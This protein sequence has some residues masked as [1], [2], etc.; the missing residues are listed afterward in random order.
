MRAPGV[1]GP[2]P[3]EPGSRNPPAAPCQQVQVGAVTRRPPAGGQ[4]DQGHVLEGTELLPNLGHQPGKCPAQAPGQGDGRLSLLH[5]L[6]RRCLAP[7]RQRLPQRERD[8]MRRWLSLRPRQLQHRPPLGGET[9]GTGGTA[10]AAARTH[11]DTGRLPVAEQLRRHTQHGFSLPALACAEEG[12]GHP[13]L[14]GTRQPGEAGARR[15]AG[16]GEQRWTPS[17]RICQD[18]AG[19]P[20]VKAHRSLPQGPTREQRSGTRSRARQPVWP[21]ARRDALRAQLWAPFIGSLTRGRRIGLR[22]SGTVP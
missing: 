16:S 8:E 4:L 1:K 14:D 3:A 2:A 18:T 7:Q 17:L 15:R 12:P 21:G 10:P 6:G 9:P 5:S 13:G 22:R 20:P 19:L 11:S